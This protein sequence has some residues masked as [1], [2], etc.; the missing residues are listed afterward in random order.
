METIP[1]K[2]IVILI[3]I[4]FNYQLYSQTENSVVVS[5]D[6]MNILYIGIDN[7][8]SVAAPGIASDKLK[9]SISNG[10]ITGSNGKYIVQPI[11]GSESIIEVSA[12]VKP[13][14]IKK[15]G[16]VVFKNKR[17]PD[18]SPCIG[19]YCNTSLYITKEELLKNTNLSVS[20]NLPFDIKFEIVSFVFSYIV[21]NKNK[22]DIPVTGNKFTQDIINSINKMNDGDELF[23]QNI[24]VKFSDGS[25][26]NLS[27]IE[28]KLKTRKTE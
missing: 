22:V 27:P 11:G 3:A 9:V 26:R 28:I 13:G 23:I 25:F 24:K 12:E 18:P 5:A 2:M 17:I 8:V 4:F 10:T 20:L 21:E 19:N 14:D 1:K 7:P 15:V 6:K 16:S